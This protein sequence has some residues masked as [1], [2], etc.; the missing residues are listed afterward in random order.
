M[1][2]VNKEKLD[3]RTE[4]VIGDALQVGSIYIYV[5]QPEV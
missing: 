1:D 5:P 3:Y 2:N 4:V